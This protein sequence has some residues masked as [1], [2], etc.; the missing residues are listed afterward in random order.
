MGFFAWLLNLYK[1]YTFWMILVTIVFV[2]LAFATMFIANIVIIIVLIVVFNNLGKK[3]KKKQLISELQKISLIES[4]EMKKVR[5][6]KE[7][8]QKELM[9]NIPPLPTGTSSGNK[10]P[11]KRSRRVY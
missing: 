4:E 1:K 2:F 8:E 5:L 3:E 7:K 9:K 11:R 10:G 6:L